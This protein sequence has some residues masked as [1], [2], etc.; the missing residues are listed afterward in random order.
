MAE[1]ELGDLSPLQR[2]LVALKEL[3]HRLALLEKD[4]NEPIAVIGIGCRF[5]GGANDPASFWELLRDARDPIREVPKERFDVDALYDPTPGV[6]G[7]VYCRVGGFVDDPDLFDAQFFRISPREAEVMDPQQRW[8]LETGWEA[9]ENAGH[10]RDLAGSRT[11]VFLG[12]SMTDYGASVARR[13]LLDNAYY[14]SG[15]TLNGVAGR[16]SYALGLRGPSLAVDTACSSSLVAVH[17]ACES[18]KRR[19][20]DL[21]LAGGVNALLDSDVL[22]N[23]CQARLLA[24]DGRCKAFDASADG[25]VRAE[26]CGIVVLK[27]LSEALADRDHVLAVIAGSAVNHGGASSGFTVP[28]PYAQRDLLVEAW[29]RAGIGPAD[30]DFLETHGT[31]TALGDPIEVEA[32]EAALGEGRDARAKLPIGTVKS[33]VGHLES[34]A[35]IAALVKVILCLQNEAIAPDLHFETP[36]PHVAWDKVRVGVV[37]RLRPWPRSGRRRVAG[38][39]SFGLSGTNAHLV[40]AEA[41]PPPPAGT[42]APERPLELLA[43]SAQSE[44][45]LRQLAGRMADHLLLHPEEPLADAGYTLHV[46]RAELPER[47]ACVACDPMAAAAKLRAFAESAPAQVVRARARRA[48]ARV[49]FLLSGQGSQYPGMGRALYEREPV[50]SAALDRCAQALGNELERP[51]LEVLFPERDE[52]EQAALHRTE[53]TQPALFALELALAELWRSWGIE[54]SVLIGHSVGEYVAACLAGAFGVEDGLRLVAARARLMQRVAEPGGMATAFCAEEK[55]RSYL[56]GAPRVAVAA[57]NSP[58]AT[59]LS[60]AQAELDAVLERM[61]A[62]GIQARKL[63]VSHAFHSP[64]ME[65]ILE[66]FRQAARSVAYAPLKLPVVSNVTGRL[67]EGVELAHADYWVE[68][69]RRCVRFADGVRSLAARR[70]SAFLEMG[71]SAALLAAAQPCVPELSDAPWLP[72]LRRGRDDFET[73]LSSLGALWA[74]GGAVDWTAYHAERPRRRRP[75]PTYPFQRERHWLEAPPAREAPADPREWLYEFRFEECPARPAARAAGGDWLVLA[76]RGGVGAR[77]KAELL[78]AGGRVVTAYAGSSWRRNEDGTI[79]LD[80]RDPGQISKLLDATDSPSQRAIVHLAALDAAD[81]GSLSAGALAQATRAVLEPALLLGQSLLRRAQGSRSKLWFVTRGAQAAGG[82]GRRL[83]PAQAS[84]WGLARVLS[85]ENPALFGGL[86]DL[87]PLDSP[88][89]AARSLVEQALLAEDENQVALRSGRRLAVRLLPLDSGAP[90]PLKL[91]RDGTYLVTGGCGAL[92]LEVARFLAE[93]GAGRLLLLGRRGAATPEA[94]RALAELRRLGADAR[95]FAVDVAARDALARLLETEAREPPLRGI[96]HA[97][98]V[99]R[100]GLFARLQWP[101][102]EQVLAP[103]AQ[104]ALH[105]HELSRGRPL[106]FFVL[107][108]SIAVIG[109]PGQ[110]NY[111]AANAF[112]DAFAHLRRAEG[113]PCQS[114]NWGPWAEAGMAKQALDLRRLAED[115]GMHAL[116]TRPALDAMERILGCGAVQASVL[117]FHWRRLFEPDFFFSRSPLLK[118][119]KALRAAARPEPARAPEPGREPAAAAAADEK[120]VEAVVRREV[121]RVLGH[122]EGQS[123]DVEAPLLE[124]GLDSLMAVQLRN[125]LGQALGVDLPLAEVLSGASAADLA[126]GAWRRLRE[127]GRPSA[128]PEAAPARA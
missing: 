69:L 14:G 61:K 73:L 59:V 125:S 118:G 17:L 39:S 128:E 37:D 40:V 24:P 96:V 124:L 33:N 10:A 92:G 30:L 15:N 94:Q 21:A 127:R 3:R 22:V 114:V 99:L 84:I 74:H 20:C 49:A 19:E 103:K 110:G 86:A 31:G 71:P 67:A 41:P 50:F 82:D 123:L 58:Q 121:A 8:A 77:L 89:D 100:D 48:R 88:A 54:P 66:E 76:D 12:V 90:T 126:R 32:I 102:F 85:S 36:N 75:L 42:G 120:E 70:P 115:R 91:R 51:L 7:K 119:L 107:F 35:G 101:D 55:A 1:R 97:A 78:Q 34:A 2:A 6:P 113:L 116:R 45:A 62:A 43:L 87:D 93:R 104:G 11:G 117:H 5:P 29:R 46:G 111:A 16:L 53:Y 25:Y 109:A 44:S 38:V 108:S 83:A 57:V 47:L 105:L 28:N 81:S 23:I 26:G 63:R 72:S 56:D 13:A 98:G 64:L 65:P 106:D 95:A 27:R 79:T 60:G 112:L 52:G 9:L 122:R 68:Q 80:P 18:L 4:R